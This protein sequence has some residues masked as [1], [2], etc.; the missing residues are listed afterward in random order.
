MRFKQRVIATLRI[1]DRELEGLQDQLEHVRKRLAVLDADMHRR[2]KA[3]RGD[4]LDRLAET[5]LARAQE[6]C[7]SCPTARDKWC[8]IQCTGE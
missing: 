6:R 8:S 4:A 1:H 5:R 7:R 3:I 2:D